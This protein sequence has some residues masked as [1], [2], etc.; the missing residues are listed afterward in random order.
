M[1]N[2]KNGNSV[3]NQLGQIDLG[4]IEMKILVERVLRNRYLET[5]SNPA[6]ERALKRV[7]NGEIE[8]DRFKQICDLYR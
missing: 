4:S 3:T 8:L 6:T 1:N 5:I 2:E 7:V